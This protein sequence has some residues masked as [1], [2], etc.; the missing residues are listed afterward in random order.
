MTSL[1]LTIQPVGTVAL[2]ALIFGESPSATAAGRGGDRARALLGRARW[3]PAPGA[4]TRGP[5][6]AEVRDRRSSGHLNRSSASGR[7]SAA[8]PGPSSALTWRP[9]PRISTTGCAP[10]LVRARSAAAASSS[11]TAIH[12]ALSSR[13]RRRCARASPRAAARPAQP[14]ATSHWPWRQARPNESVIRTAGATPSQRVAAGPERA[15]RAVGVA[16]QQDQRV[17][18]GGVGGV[19]A[20]VGA[21]EAVV[22][23]ADQHALRVARSTS[24]GL[25]EHDLDVARVLV[26]FAARA[27]LRAGGRL[28]LGEPADPALGLGDDLVGDHEHVAVGELVPA[29]SRARGDQ[30]PRGRRP[31]RISGSPSSATARDHSTWLRSQLASMPRVCAAPPWVDSRLAS[32]ASRSSGV[33]MSSASDGHLDDLGG[34]RLP[35]LRRARRGAGGCRARTTASARPAGSAAARWCRCRGGRARSAPSAR[36]RPAEQRVELG[37]VEQR[38]VAGHE[39]HA[40]GPGLERGAIPQRGRRVV[41]LA[42]RRRAPSRRSRRRSAGRRGRR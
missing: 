42:R 4:A 34:R 38:A 6:C 12:V 39:Q 18:A 2:A 33:S 37:R 1:M 15:R 35:R 9:A 27:R 25:V 22:G 19:D 26:E 28:D 23:H 17:L 24:L 5:R 40:V 31:G 32:S 8:A 13:P 20:G 41:A 11:A 14:I 7:S 16:R 29:A 36:P 10:S 21:H 3:A 30:L